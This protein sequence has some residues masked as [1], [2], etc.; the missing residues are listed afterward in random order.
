MSRHFLDQSE[1]K[2][3]PLDLPRMASAA[4]ICFEFWLGLFV[5]IGWGNY[6]GF[7]TLIW[8]AL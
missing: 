8:K 5:V 4:C 6:F 2:L 3:K 1:E 7:T